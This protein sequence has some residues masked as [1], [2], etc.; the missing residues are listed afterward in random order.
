MGKTNLNNQKA[1]IKC[2]VFGILI[3]I[4]VMLLF[5]VIFSL[6]IMYAQLDRALSAPLASLCIAIGV[7]VSSY[8]VAFCIG[9]KGY[10]IGLVTALIYLAILSLVSAVLN[11]TEIGINALFRFVIVFLSGLIGGILGVGKKNKRKYI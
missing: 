7:I 3:G 9:E 2:F 4:A 5:L 8:F 6:V 11:G 1:K 10:L